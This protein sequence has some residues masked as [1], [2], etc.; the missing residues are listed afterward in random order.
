MINLQNRLRKILFPVDRDT[1]LYSRFRLGLEI[2][3]RR[4]ITFPD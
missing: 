2:L 4:L 3:L 1:K